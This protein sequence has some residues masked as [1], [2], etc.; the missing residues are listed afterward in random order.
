MNLFERLMY[1]RLCN[2]QPYDG[3]A[4]S[5]IRSHPRLL[6]LS[7]LKRRSN[8]QQIRRRHAADGG[9]PEPTGDKPTPSAEP[10]GLEKYGLT[11]E[12]AELDSKAVELCGPW[13]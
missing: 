3:G 5:S 8:R 6:R 9:K 12:G 10:I 2:E 11:A 13:R 7:N 1:R 4:L